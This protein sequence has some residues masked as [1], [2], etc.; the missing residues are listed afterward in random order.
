MMNEHYFV[1][2]AM[3]DGV[4]A[5]A[6]DFALNKISVA[7]VISELLERNEKLETEVKEL[8]QELDDAYNTVTHHKEQRTVADLRVEALEKTNQALE[9]NVKYYRD[10]LYSFTEFLYG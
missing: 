4:R 10:R 6:I 1:A 9:E 5:E 3:A 7:Q 8:H 2:D